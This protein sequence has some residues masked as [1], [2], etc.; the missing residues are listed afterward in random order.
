[1]ETTTINSV[2]IQTRFNDCEPFSKFV[3]NGKTSEGR[4]LN[5]YKRY[6]GDDYNVRL[7]QFEEYYQPIVH[8]QM[9][10]ECVQRYVDMLQRYGECFDKRQQ[11]VIVDALFSTYSDF[12]YEHS[13]KLFVTYNHELNEWQYSMGVNSNKDSFNWVNQTDK[14]KTFA[15]CMMETIHYYE[16]VRAREEWVKEQI[17]VAKQQPR[18]ARD[19]R[20]MRLAKRHLETALQHSFEL[21]SDINAERS[22]YETER[23]VRQMD[24]VKHQFVLVDLLRMFLETINEVKIVNQYTDD[25]KYV[26]LTAEEA[27]LKTID[28]FYGRTSHPFPASVIRDFYEATQSSY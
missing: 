2:S 5:K 19:E 4:K 8:V 16:N 20:C 15:V 13:Q 24:S 12:M 21:V 6:F 3:V 18:S 27:T 26:L 23:I 11:A 25:E 22:V 1:M 10:E 9:K 17:E 28:R 7:I 14:K